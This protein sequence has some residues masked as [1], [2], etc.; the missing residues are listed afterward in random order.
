MPK[1]LAATDL[2]RR[3]ANVLGRSARLARRLGA[4]VIYVHV[5]RSR[6]RGVGRIARTMLRPGRPTL[7][8]LDR[9]QAEASAHP[10]V[11]ISCCVLDGA[12]H[13]ALIALARAEDPALVVLGL[14]RERP[15]DLLRL[16]TMERVVLGVDAPVL[17]AH[18]TPEADYARVLGAVSFAPSCARA[19]G[20][21]AQI[22]PDAAIHAI[23]ALRM[24]LRDRLSPTE[25]ADT[26]SMTEAELLRDAFCAMPDI[27]QTL[28]RPE[29][30]IGGVH[31]V[32]GFRID[33]LRPDLLTIGTHSG[34]DA[35]ALGN[36]ARDLMRKPPADLLVVKP[37]PAG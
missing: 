34:R 6:P 17:I 35:T 3:S 27:P 26:P 32:L 37:P 22:A 1:I 10:D 23:H 14:H 21:A 11:A 20:V 28:H 30:V 19:L 29:I 15:L 16:T 8:P 4:S 25:A 33:E 9:L 36:Y 2:T 13:E 5:P 12:P 18:R 24:P 7:T 31:E